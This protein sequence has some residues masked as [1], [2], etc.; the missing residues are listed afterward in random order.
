MMNHESVRRMC[1]GGVRLVRSRLGPSGALLTSLVAL[2]V[3][4]RYVCVWVCVYVCMCVCAG[5][6]SHYD[7]VFR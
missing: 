5:W 3:L 1:S 2:V 7:S 4:V 6:G